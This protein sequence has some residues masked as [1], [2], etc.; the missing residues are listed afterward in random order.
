MALGVRFRYLV[1]GDYNQDPDPSVGGF[2][3]GLLA[4]KHLFSWGGI[5]L[6]VPLAAGF[7]AW[8]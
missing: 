4:N 8:T 6:D 1:G 2:L 3:L 7:E 5:L